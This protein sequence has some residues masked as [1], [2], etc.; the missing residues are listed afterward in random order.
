MLFLRD[1]ARMRALFLPDNKRSVICAGVHA[2][3]RVDRDVASAIT[4]PSS[5]PASWAITPIF[6]SQ[7][8]HA[9]MGLRSYSVVEKN[10]RRHLQAMKM[11][12]RVLYAHRDH[13]EIFRCARGHELRHSRIDCP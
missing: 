1:S 7:R 3:S 6:K 11:Q 5:S 10:R 8:G 13:P 2:E 4:L 9:I 12:R